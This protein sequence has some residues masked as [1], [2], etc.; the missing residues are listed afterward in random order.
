MIWN[1]DWVIFI[2]D[3]DQDLKHNEV[4]TTCKRQVLQGA[5]Y[6]PGYKLADGLHQLLFLPTWL[7][8]YQTSHHVAGDFDDRNLFYPLLWF[9]EV[10]Y[11]WF[12]CDNIRG[13]LPVT[14]TSLHTFSFS[15]VKWSVYLDEGALINSFWTENLGK[16]TNRSR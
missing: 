8:I 13:T 14:S 6:W 3:D 16:F 10:G 7:H 9:T 11:F 5:W 2:S 15:S 1:L 4:H 12:L